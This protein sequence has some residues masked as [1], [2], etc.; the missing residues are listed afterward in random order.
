MHL[1]YALLIFVR[2]QKICSPVFQWI[3]IY[4]SQKGIAQSLTDTVIFQKMIAL[5]RSNNCTNWKSSIFII[6]ACLKDQYSGILS[7]IVEHIAST[8]Y[9]NESFYRNNDKC[10]QSVPLATHDVAVVA[11]NAYW[12]SAYE[13][14]IQAIF[15]L[16]VASI[17]MQCL[18]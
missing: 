9:A 1:L 5:R 12:N 17:Y 2:L 10:L 4:Q 11:T 6:L 3:E 7:S 16:W 18:V 13:F 14:Q 8:L 15:Y